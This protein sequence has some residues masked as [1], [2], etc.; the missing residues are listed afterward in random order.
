MQEIARHQ[1]QQRRVKP[2]A[3]Q[4]AQHHVVA[5]DDAHRRSQRKHQQPGP[6]P[7]EA[8]QPQPQQRGQREGRRHVV[9]SHPHHNGVEI[10]ADLAC[11]RNVHQDAAFQK[12]M[13]HQ[14]PEQQKRYPARR[15]VRA[16]GG[17]VMDVPML[18][19]LRKHFEQ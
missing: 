17:F 2:A 14:R 9:Q 1:A 19:A 7:P 5:D 18:H 13:H 12:R 16:V 8:A 10:P 6:H 11:F 3:Q 4:L 15:I